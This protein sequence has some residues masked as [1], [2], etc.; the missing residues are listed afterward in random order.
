MSDQ[1]QFSTSR[2]KPLP[3][4]A[5]ETAHGV[6]FSI[7]SVNATGATLVLFASGIDQALCEIEL[8]SHHHRTGKV[9]H[10]EVCGVDENIR[11]G[12][13][14]EGPN[15]P[16]KGHRF[17]RR[18]ILIDPYAKALT[19]GAV[20]GEP[21]IRRSID[22]EKD[23]HYFPRRC[24]LAPSEFDWEDLS[25]LR[26]PLEDSVIYEL[27]VRGYTV[28]KSSGVK[29]RGTYQGLTE[30]I[31]YLK[32]LGITAV[33]LMP[34]F[35]FD[36]NENLRKDPGTGKLLRNFWG[37]SPV[38]FFAPK[39]S[40]AAE[41]RGA[42]QVREFREMVREFHRAG[43]EVILDVVFN[44]TAEG[45]ER[46]PTISFRGIDNATYYIHDRKGKYA[47][48]SG[49]GNTFNCNDPTNQSLIIDCLRYWVSEMRVDGFRF[50]LASIL[51]RGPDGEVLKNPP[52]I[53][54]IARDPVLADTK[55][56]AEAWDAAGL[57]QVGNF[58]G[59]GR[60]SEWNG[61]FRD[62]WRMFWKGFPGMVSQVASRICGSDD[63][64]KLRPGQ[65]INF[66]TAHDGFTL[67]DLVSY[68]DKHNEANGEENQDGENNNFSQNF[69]V[70][71][72]TGDGNINRLR[73]QMMKN[74]LASL[75]LSQGAPM[76]LAGD[77]FART[78]KGNN[79]AYCQDN[80]I[81]WVDWK[82]TEGNSDL[83]RFTRLLIALR[84]R[85]SL[86]RRRTFFQNGK[87]ISWHGATPGGADWS[88][89][90]HWLAFLLEGKEAPKGP[91][92]SLFVMMNASEE[93]HYFSI[94]DAGSD[95]LLVADTS[96]DSPN[97]F[98][99]DKNSGE[100]VGR[101][102]SRYRVRPRSM[103]ILETRE[104]T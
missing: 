9:W 60:W 84:K 75:F 20:W 97:D 76:L 88:Q 19:G 103:V 83:M 5:T 51:G 26:T 94:P 62:H 29:A 98:H 7:Y 11:Y 33:E 18:L 56:I 43:I 44:H 41:G 23:Y 100:N 91:E 73:K 86:L 53:E 57:N 6:N 68:D 35:E 89:E 36:E 15:Q 49:C 12:W 87:G 16:E 92:P 79:N 10:I 101:G 81:N 17:D 39:S 25:P 50:D 69:G 48:F 46:G 93:K 59:S 102:C 30:K 95:W 52:L 40:Y 45:D 31:P 27:H 8:D 24:C 85:H 38:C 65:S 82:F 1:A 47:N 74:M 32:E 21:E 22:P 14:I 78:Q 28:H 3:F 37:Y 71:G 2:G 72:P 90:A 77:E 70:E 104:A 34:V 67:H 63:L 4:G 64:Y 13:R 42:N 96:R 58:P 80:E 55:M 54:R 99:E 61:Y 66:I